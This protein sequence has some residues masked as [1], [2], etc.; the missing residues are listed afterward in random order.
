[1]TGISHEAHRAQRRDLLRDMGLFFAGVVAGP[2]L[3]TLSFRLTPMSVS[4]WVPVFVVVVL[5]GVMFFL[6]HW[7]WLALG[8]FISSS[9]WIVFI[10][11]L[12]AGVA[13]GDW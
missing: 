9:I 1:M 3:L 2:A 11:W 4:F 8:M 12:T 6:L 5:I 10:V 13:G 7:K